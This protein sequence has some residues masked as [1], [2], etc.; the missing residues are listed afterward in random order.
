ME[1][2]LNKIDMELRERINEATSEKKIHRK[3]EIQGISNN[4]EKN[5]NGEK[6]KKFVLPDKDFKD[7][8]ILITAEKNEKI[9]IDVDAFRDNCN[10]LDPDRGSFLDVRK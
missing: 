10:V 6:K 3:N 8:K 7:N 9:S 1:Y 2:R 4:N 5:H